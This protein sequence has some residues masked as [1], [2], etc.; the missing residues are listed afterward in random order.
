M[1]WSPSPL[2]RGPRQCLNPR[3]WDLA[4]CCSPQPHQRILGEED[5]TPPVPWGCLHPHREPQ[6]PPRHPPRAEHTLTARLWTW[7]VRRAWLRLECLLRACAEVC[8]LWEPARGGSRDAG[9]HDTP[10]LGTAPAAHP[11]PGTSLP[12]LCG[13]TGSCHRSPTSPGDGLWGG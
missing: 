7:M 2:P 4:P 13:R 5:V 1:L 3:V 11:L 8:R 9:G 10:C 6:P 12:E